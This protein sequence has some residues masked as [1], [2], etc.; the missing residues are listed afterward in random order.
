M[1]SNRLSSVQ[2][3]RDAARQRLIDNRRRNA[4]R[5]AAIQSDR[6]TPDTPKAEQ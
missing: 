3:R 4:A 6:K 2:L 5:T 1:Q